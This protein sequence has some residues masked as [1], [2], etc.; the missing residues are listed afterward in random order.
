[1]FTYCNAESTAHAPQSYLLQTNL[2]TKSQCYLHRRVCASPPVCSTCVFQHHPDSKLAPLLL[3]CHYLYLSPL[4]F[5]LPLPAFLETMG[6]RSRKP[7]AQLTTT[8]EAQLSESDSEMQPPTKHS[9][10]NFDLDSLLLDSSPVLS[11]SNH[12]NLE[13]IIACCDVQDKRTTPKYMDLIRKAAMA[14]RKAVEDNKNDKDDIKDMLANIQTEVNN[15]RTSKP[16]PSFSAIAASRPQQPVTPEQCQ[17]HTLFVSSNQPNSGDVISGK[18][19][20][21]ILELRKDR[22]MLKINKI[23]KYNKGNIIKVPQTEDLDALIT[24]FKNL[25]EINQVAK[26]FVPNPRDPTIVLKRVHKLTEGPKLPSILSNINCDLKGSDNE[27][28]F[29]FELKSNSQFRDIVLRVSPRVFQILK[30]HKTLYTEFEAVHW[31]YK[32]FVRQC[33]FCFEFGTHRAADCPSKNNSICADC[34]AQGNHSCSKVNKC[35]NC[36][37]HHRANSSQDTSHRPNSP[38]CP[39]YKKQIEKII[40]QTAFYPLPTNTATHHQPS[41][42]TSSPMS[43][44]GS[45]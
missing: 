20:K 6:K 10:T 9:K 24:H 28:R 19:N 22:P 36:T 42:S 16:I 7:P 37:K 3:K 15:L 30:H 38:S 35:H 8:I 45:N 12:D 21:A 4:P 26:V 34:G 2:L 32:A 41:Y 31:E 44:D 14:I 1:M 17:E 39:L 25:D 33:K 40:N 29:L 27:I 11:H 5:L 18:V 23:I 43:I 13:L